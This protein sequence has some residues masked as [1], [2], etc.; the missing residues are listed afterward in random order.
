MFTLVLLGARSLARPGELR[1]PKSEREGKLEE[2]F[3]NKLA[4]VS[5]SLALARR[6]HN[7]EATRS[8]CFSLVGAQAKTQ[9]GA[10]ISVF[11]LP[12]FFF[13]PSANRSASGERWANGRPTVCGPL[14]SR[15]G[16][17]CPREWT[18]LAC[19][20]SSWHHSSEP[21][22]RDS[23][24]STWLMGKPQ[25]SC[26]APHCVFESGTQSAANYASQVSS[27]NGPPMGQRLS[28]A[29]FRA[30][31]RACW[32]KSSALLGLPSQSSPFG[33]GFRH[34][35]ACLAFSPGELRAIRGFSGFCPTTI[36]II[37]PPIIIYYVLFP[38]LQPF[39]DQSELVRAANSCEQSW[40]CIAPQMGP[41][42][43]LVLTSLRV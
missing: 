15:I 28:R 39:Q 25:S 11:F 18:A 31:S 14:C 35:C 30:H 22:A 41:H 27:S 36:T 23:I 37:F 9:I 29:Q 2:I 38:L 1:R 5:L 6:P 20:R 19:W 24:T 10:P 3:Q 7:K 43:R 4:S 32:G 12:F 13:F 42:L 34:F 8:A 17:H 26:R 40:I 16:D 21:H 33:R